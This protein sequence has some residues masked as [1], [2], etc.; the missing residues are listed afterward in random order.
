MCVTSNDVICTSRYFKIL[1]DSCFSTLIIHESH[2]CIHKFNTR[3]T[4]KNKW[5]TMAWSCLTLFKV[6]VGLKLP[7]LN[8]TAHIS[9]PF[10]NHWPKKSYNVIFGKDLLR[11][12]WISQGFQK[13]HGLERIQDANETCYCKIKKYF[14]IQI[15]EMLGIQLIG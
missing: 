13:N 3:E 1:M 8:T 5:S 4:Y 6:K 7:E 2:I 11:E 12:L 15:V 9:A 10:H 14:A